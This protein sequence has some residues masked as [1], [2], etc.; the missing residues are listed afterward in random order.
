MISYKASEVDDVQTLDD[1]FGCDAKLMSLTQRKC[2]LG[3]SAN[4]LLPKDTR[5]LLTLDVDDN[6]DDDDDIRLRQD[7]LTCLSA[8]AFSTTDIVFQLPRRK[9]GSAVG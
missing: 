6:N 5:F 4:V 1:D 2:T 8:L 7:L 9:V 3:S